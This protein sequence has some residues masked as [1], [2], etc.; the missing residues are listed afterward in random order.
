MTDRTNF[1]KL[2]ADIPDTLRNEACAEALVDQ[3]RKTPEAV[4]PQAASLLVYDVLRERL[5]VTHQVPDV[6]ANARVTAVFLL[7]CREMARHPRG[8]DPAVMSQM[9]ETVEN[10]S[11]LPVGAHDPVLRALAAGYED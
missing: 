3:T 2:L 10:L 11:E 8:L 9:R 5:S 4:V 7:L 6:D 1:D